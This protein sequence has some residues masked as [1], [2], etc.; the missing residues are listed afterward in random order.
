MP[1]IHHPRRPAVY[2]ARSADVLAVVGAFRAG[3]DGLV[4]LGQVEDDIGDRPAV[5]PRVRPPLRLGQQA[6]DALQP[7]RLRDKVVN[8]RQGG[9]PHSVDVAALPT[10]SLTAGPVTC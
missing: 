8:D 2:G 7:Q 10:Y 9:P 4:G 1:A 3:R 5:G 6:E